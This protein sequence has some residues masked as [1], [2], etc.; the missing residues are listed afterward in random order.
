MC[1]TS[2]CILNLMRYSTLKF[3]FACLS[4]TASIALPSCGQNTA[5][6]LA[7]A[8]GAEGGA[9]DA[10]TAKANNYPDVPGTVIFHSPASSRLFVG[11]PGIAILP[12]GNYVAKND[13]F[14]YG[15][16]DTRAITRVFGSSDKG[17]SWQ[18]LSVVNNCFWSSIFVNK[19]ALYMLGTSKQYGHLVIFRSEDGG[20]TW[21]EPTDEN[22]G[23]LR[24]DGKFHT[25]PTPIVEHDGRLWRGVEDANGPG[26]WGSMFRAFVMSAPVD[27]DLL[28]ASSWTSSNSLER[29]AKWNNND[30]GGWLEGNAVVAP[31][32]NIVD[33]LRVAANAPDA[34]AAIVQISKDGK[35]ASFD[36]NNGIVQMPGAG[37]KFS[38]RFDPQTKKYWSLS[39]AVP[40][41]HRAKDSGGIRNTLALISSTDLRNWN[42]DT[43]LLYNPDISKHGFQYLDWQ[44]DGND[45][46]A[47]SRTAYDDGEGGAENYH[48]ANFLT[49]HRFKNFRT[50]T[51]KDGVQIPKQ[52][53]VHAETANFDIDGAQFEMA[54]L[55]RNSK[56]Y[57]NRDYV[58]L[59]VPDKFSGGQF[60]RLSG[61][62]PADISVTAKKDGMIYFATAMSQPGVDLK[63]W[64]KTG[65][66]LNYSDGAKT[67]M[68]VFGRAVK[69]GDEVTIPQGNWVGSAVLVEAE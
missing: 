25:A 42:I 69:A 53:A 58:W 60:T 12:N 38:I 24:A 63:G 64:T 19:G 52:A 26:G 68:T 36:P 41:R 2:A 51:M 32:G 57:S 11:S 67:E 33:V 30:F 44:F 5:P 46:I 4:A 22:N 31:S 37:T 17:K 23:V 50:L 28:K 43:V 16:E 49:F 6:K 56:I 8:G 40:K 55:A 35:T 27:A 3:A 14:G 13:E 47:A 48:N 15:I 1:F 54:P 18:P 39:N 61:G 7:V 65:D 66:T 62:V 45:I 21:T 29:D 9:T 34:V 20:K 59:N 10:A